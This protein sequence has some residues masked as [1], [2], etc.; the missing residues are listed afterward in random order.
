MKSGRSQ[1]N[2]NAVVDM[3]FRAA[4]KSWQSWEKLDEPPSMIVA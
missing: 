3:R 1:I 4:Q 2:G